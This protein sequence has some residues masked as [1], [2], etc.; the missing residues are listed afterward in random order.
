MKRFF[1]AAALAVALG[2]AGANAQTAQAQSSNVLATGQYSQDPD[3]R[4]DLLEV[5]RVSGGALLVRW[6]LMNTA[7][8]AASGGFASTS[9]G[10]K[11]SY[12]F[13]WEQLFVIDPAE[14]KKYM[15]L[16]DSNNG[17]IAEIFEGELPPGAQR[18][19][20]AKFPAPPASSTKVSVSIP[21]FA[22]FEDVPVAQ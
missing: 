8:Q 14:N 16:T 13:S 18:L 11:I 10:K 1:G 2:A 4:C 7:G 6:R 17:R 5:K 20:W 19:D 15:V 12:N 3:L 22:P 9:G 21:R